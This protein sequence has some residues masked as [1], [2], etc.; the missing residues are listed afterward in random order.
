MKG[1]LRQARKVLGYVLLLRLQLAR[2]CVGRDAGGRM[3]LGFD[4][5][6]S[7]NTVG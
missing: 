3:L 6:P 1:C 5:M 4:G 2:F 7:I